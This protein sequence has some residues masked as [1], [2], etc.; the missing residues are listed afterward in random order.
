MAH[1]EL[2]QLRDQVEQLDDLHR[3]TEDRLAR[4]LAEIQKLRIEQ[5]RATQHLQRTALMA[6][7]LYQYLIMHTNHEIHGTTLA[8]HVES[9]IKKHSEIVPHARGE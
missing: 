7:C 8:G 3:H 6:Y 5:H 4:A 2:E 1:S 9:Q